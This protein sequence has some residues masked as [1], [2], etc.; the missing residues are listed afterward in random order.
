MKNKAFSLIEVIVA[1]AIIAVLASFVTP[2]VRLQLAKGKDT[3]AIAFLGT[4]RLAAQM[5]QMEHTEALILE[6]DYD[7]EA[8]V[9]EA[10]GKLEGYLDPK[11]KEI[12][13][14]GKLAVGASRTTATGNI[15][16]GGE[17]SFTFKNPNA[18]GT[19]DGIYLW[20]KPVGD[21]GEFD[22]RGQKWTSY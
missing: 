11:A 21:L 14:S 1:V 13:S 7:N 20:L 19:S 18:T 2:Q 3:K 4:A 5:Y 15:K 6:A 12:V 8:K 16:Y 22:S 17:V 10:L 9:K